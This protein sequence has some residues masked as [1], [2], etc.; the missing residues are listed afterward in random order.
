MNS[1]YFLHLSLGLGS[2]FLLLF[3]VISTLCCFSPDA[4]CE[5]KWICIIHSMLFCSAL[6]PATFIYNVW[7]MGRCTEQLIVFFTASPFLS[8]AKLFTQLSQPTHHSQIASM[9]PKHYIHISDKHWHFFSLN[10]TSLSLR[11]HWWTTVTVYPFIV[12]FLL[13]NCSV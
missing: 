13:W 8:L 4:F 10:E 6:F 3:C 9:Q 12:F 5:V 7:L 11:T 1:Y 2:F